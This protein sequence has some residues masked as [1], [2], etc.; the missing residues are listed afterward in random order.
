[1]LP[2]KRHLPRLKGG[3]PSPVARYSVANISAKMTVA[4]SRGGRRGVAGADE[5]QAAVGVAGEPDGLR[6]GVGGRGGTL[7][8]CGP[9]NS[10][11]I[12]ADGKVGSGPL[13]LLSK[14]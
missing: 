2:V 7:H 4:V 3:I 12:L 5:A 8:G 11:R 1:M 9:R 13:P 6:V 10:G 14:K